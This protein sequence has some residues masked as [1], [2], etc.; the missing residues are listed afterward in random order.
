MP[1]KPVA[2]EETKPRKSKLAKSSKV[3]TSKPA[4]KG[5]ASK[6]AKGGKRAST[7]PPKGAVNPFAAVVRGLRKKMSKTMK[8]FA[9]DVGLKHGPAIARLESDDYF[10][11]SV[12]TMLRIADEVGGELSISIKLSK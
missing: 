5:K 10:G 7:T 6:P 4:K 9:E 2:V 1:K 11:T 12:A 8:E 3:K